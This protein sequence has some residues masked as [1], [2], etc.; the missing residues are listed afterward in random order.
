VAHIFVTSRMMYDHIVFATMEVE[1][2]LIMRSPVLVVRKILVQKL[3][4]DVPSWVS[5]KSSDCGGLKSHRTGGST[6][7]AHHLLGEST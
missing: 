7:G 6:P 4:T 2:V 3:G 1:V 5:S